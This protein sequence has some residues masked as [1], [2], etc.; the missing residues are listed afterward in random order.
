MKKK[1]IATLMLIAAVTIG[2]ASYAEDKQAA[3][4]QAQGKK[5]TNCPVMTGNKINK[6]MYVDVKGYRIYVCCAGCIGKIKADP[7]KYIKKM[8]AQGIA[9]E[10]APAPK[11]TPKQDS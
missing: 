1:S 11:E 3:P 7:D 4:E 2:M 9:L 6:N 10:K 8:K 5:Q